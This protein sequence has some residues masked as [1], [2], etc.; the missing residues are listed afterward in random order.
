VTPPSLTTPARVTAT[1][2]GSHGT[3]PLESVT[4]YAHSEGVWK[5]TQSRA[6]SY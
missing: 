2:N 5:A 1:I 3:W 6:T 4:Q